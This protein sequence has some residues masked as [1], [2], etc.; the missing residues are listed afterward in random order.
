MQQRYKDGKLWEQL[1]HWDEEGYVMSC[2][3]PGEDIYTETGDKPMKDDSG[4]VSGHA[5]TLLAAK[6]TSEGHK[7]VQ[8]RNPWGNFEWQ[9][10]E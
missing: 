7:L 4:L 10:K 8:L 5:Y 1:V 3:T 9:G 2:S 6:E